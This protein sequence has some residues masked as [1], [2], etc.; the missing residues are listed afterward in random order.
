MTALSARFARRFPG[1]AVIRA[2]MDLP[3]GR[4]D[5]TVLFGPSGA[6]KTTILRCLAG[7]ETPDEGAIRLGGETWF[8]ADAGVNRPPQAR[9]VGFLFQDHALFPHLTVAGNVGYGIS[10]LPRA[11]RDRRVTEGLAFVGLSGVA[12]RRPREL[13]GGESQRVA[14]ARA[15]ARHPALLLLDEP[16]SALDTPLRARLRSELRALLAA[17]DIPSLVVT[18]D[19]GEA[20]ALGDRV[21]VVVDGAIRQVGPVDDVFSR[22]ADVSVAH[23]TGVE[24]VLAGHVVAERDGVLTVSIGPGTLAVADRDGTRGDVFV[25]LRAEDVLLERGAPAARESARN[26]LAARVTSVSSE[27]PLVRVGLDC[28]FPLSALVTRPA[29]DEL[30]LAPGAEVTAVVKAASVVLVARATRL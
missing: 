29:R 10:D 22:P 4:A 25:C 14:L 27:G 16:L 24:S 9:R 18:H 1:G 17:L 19:R 28:G 30:G 7:L 2:E 21:A 23:V 15:L 8:D 3:L 6:G 13:S 20:L 5:V 11:E 26:H 12:A